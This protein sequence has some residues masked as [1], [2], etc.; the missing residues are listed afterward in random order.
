MTDSGGLR[1]T[2]PTRRQVARPAPRPASDLDSLR[3][4][5]ANIPPTTGQWLALALPGGAGVAAWGLWPDI[6]WAIAHV[7][8]GL[9]F[10]IAS[11]T[12][13]GAVLLALLNRPPPDLSADRLPRYT[14]IAPLYKE[15]E[16]APHLVAALA[17][18]DYP[19][20][21][22]QVMIAV[23][24]DDEETRA[25]LEAMALPAHFEITATPPGTPRTKPRACNVALER[26]TGELLTIYDAEDRPHALQLREAAARFAA[27]SPRL[28]CLQAPLRIDPDRRFLP[29]QFALEYAAQFDVLLP[30]L[31]RLGLPFPLGGTSN[32]F[33]ASALHAVGGW[34]PWNVTEDADLGFRL[35]AEGYQLGVLRRPTFEPAP[36]RLS[37]WLPQ[38]TRWVKGYMQTFGVQT[39]YPP[40]WRTGV[41]TAFALTLGVAISG[42]VMHAPAFAWTAVGAVLWLMGG[43][44]WLTLYDCLLLAVG[45]ASATATTAA[46]LVLGGR[47]TTIRDL[48]VAPA[49]WPLQSLAAAH[50]IV[51][52]IRAPYHWDKTRHAPRNRAEAGQDAT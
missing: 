10:A 25:A 30:A 1:R 6:T 32:H 36:D 43:Q 37:D 46:G 28:A 3:R 38:R 8:L 27:G 31:A 14:V 9:L 4:E 51:Q 35:A 39:R 48:L 17:A 13:L 7:L 44:G 41:M 2:A 45:W 26:A 24:A 40:H 11:L 52:L 19:A 42:S 50:A 12:R 47:P 21:R 18:I 34:D 33:R 49:Y 15:A 23:E 5:G 20:A 22:L 29:R 16:I